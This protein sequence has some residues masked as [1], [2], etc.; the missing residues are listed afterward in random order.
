[1]EEITKANGS[2][3]EPIFEQLCTSCDFV[4][5]LGRK[6]APDKQ[7]LDANREAV[8]GKI[9]H[10]CPL[11]EQIQALVPIGTR[12]D[13][14]KLDLGNIN[15]FIAVNRPRPKDTARPYDALEIIISRPGELKNYPCPE[16]G[17]AGPTAAETTSG[18]LHHSTKRKSR[19]LPF[20]PLSVDY[21]LI[22]T[23]MNHCQTNHGQT[24]HMVEGLSLRGFK[25]IDCATGAVVPLPHKSERY[26][27]LSYV[28]GRPRSDQHGYPPTVRDSMVVTL[29]LGMRYLWVDRYV[30]HS[31]RLTH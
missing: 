13:T 9:T 26:I 16:F 11:C 22:R 6:D 18:L 7:T 12:I 28:W 1:M 10:G 4:R 8:W 3:F 2:H 29:K 24:C 30:S 31:P 19:I 14:V 17:L 23:W 5:W 15:D 20:D 21:D 25:V 27:A